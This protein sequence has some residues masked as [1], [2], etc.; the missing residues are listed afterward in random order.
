MALLLRQRW[1]G[2]KNVLSDLG[3]CRAVFITVSLAIS[4]SV[5]VL[6]YVIA[7]LAWFLTKSLVGH[8]PQLAGSDGTRRQFGA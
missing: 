1:S 7:Y 6:G 5:Y 4:I 3:V 2:I 8:W